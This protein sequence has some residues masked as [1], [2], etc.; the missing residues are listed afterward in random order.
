MAFSTKHI[1]LIT[2]CLQE[3]QQYFYADYCVGTLVVD[4]A[5]WCLSSFLQRDFAA[6]LPIDFDLQQF[7]SQL[8]D[9]FTLSQILALE[10][11]QGNMHWVFLKTDIVDYYGTDYLRVLLIPLSKQFFLVLLVY[12]GKFGFF[13]SF[14]YLLASGI[15]EF[16]VFLLSI[17][18]LDAFIASPYFSTFSAS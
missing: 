4:R 14:K 1:S 2:Y 17:T 15:F 7:A 18:E 13:Y 9:F 8:T 12:S 6:R 3:I 16:L 10:T 11:R 5:G